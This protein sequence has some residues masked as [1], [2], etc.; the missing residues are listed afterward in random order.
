MDPNKQELLAPAEAA[1]LLGISLT[2]LQKDRVRPGGPRIVGYTRTAGGHARYR[3][4]DINRFLELQAVATGKDPEWAKAEGVCRKVAHEAEQR[5]ANG[6]KASD[7][8]REIPP[9]LRELL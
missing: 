3:R 4:S 9:E 2:T 1:A 8:L 7:G 6:W 5:I